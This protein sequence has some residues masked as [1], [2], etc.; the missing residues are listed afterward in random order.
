MELCICR[1]V[2][3]HF[4]TFSSVLRFLLVFLYL[5][6]VD[7]QSPCYFDR[8]RRVPTRCMPSF[9]NAAFTKPVVSNNTCGTPPSEFCVQTGVTSPS[10]ECT[11]CDAS[12]MRYRHP[13]VFI[14]DIKND[15][16]RTWWQSE[17]M[18]ENP[19]KPVTLTLDLRKSYDVSYIRI[20]FRSPRPESM[21]IYKRTSTSPNAP[22]IPYQYFSDSC[23]KTYKVPTRGIVTRENQQVALCTDE[24]SGISPLTGGNIAFTTLMGRPDY[25]N[26]DNSPALQ[27]WVTASAIRIDL[28]RMNTFGDEVFG[29]EN[30]LRSYY[31]AIIDLAV[32]GRC[33]C[34][35]HA[36]SC[37]NYQLANGRLE[38]RCV[39][40][41]NT[42]G[43]DCQECKRRFNNRPWARATEDSA[44]EC[45][46]LCK[47]FFISN[48]GSLLA[49]SSVILHNIGINLALEQSVCAIALF[50][51]RS[52]RPHVGDKNV[53]SEEVL[54]L[55]SLHYFQ[56][57]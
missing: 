57:F 23:E 30:V 12:D 20:R 22:W 28:D 52:D 11:L 7:S 36:A 29:D 8:E 55:I 42:A 15:Q 18:L 56:P 47:S 1:R 6:G 26:F 27:E 40:E 46:G 48:F 16:N 31:F 5:Q 54:G 33:K 53:F 25:L 32:G 50:E 9:G 39:C 45:Q 17:T 44:N 4:I 43:V 51:C 35:G 37:K 21:A 19:D 41:H 14:T 49:F 10:K 13:A 2:Q 3:K 24:F 38:L 34:N